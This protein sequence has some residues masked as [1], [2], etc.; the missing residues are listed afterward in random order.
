M[1]SF[2]G[3]PSPPAIPSFRQQRAHRGIPTRENIPG[4]VH[5]AVHP[6]RAVRTGQGPPHRASTVSSSAGSTAARGM[7]WRWLQD[8][9]VVSHQHEAFPGVG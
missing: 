7:A 1:V 5:S 8:A 3:V 2:A 6:H 4:I 9:T